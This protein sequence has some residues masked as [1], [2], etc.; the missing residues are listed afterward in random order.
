MRKQKEI[1]DDK[2]RVYY[3]GKVVLITGGSGSIGSELCRQL[4]KM[5]PKQLIVLDIYE[6]CA[7]LTICNKD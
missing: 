7:V 1:I 3:K 2:T 4:V 5:E 6:N